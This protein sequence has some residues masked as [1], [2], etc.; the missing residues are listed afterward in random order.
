MLAFKDVFFKEF[1]TLTNSGVVYKVS[2]HDYDGFYIGETKRRLQQRLQEHK[3]QSYSSLNKHSS[4]TSHTVGYDSPVIL[5]TDTS[6]YRLTIKE[7]LHI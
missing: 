5:A 7:A 4:E 1:A 6:D 2:C 3:Q